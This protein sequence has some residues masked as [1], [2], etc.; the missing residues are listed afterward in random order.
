MNIWTIVATSKINC[1]GTHAGWQL[2]LELL[3]PKIFLTQASKRLFKSGEVCPVKSGL[4]TE[5]PLSL[6]YSFEAAPGPWFSEP[7]LCKAQQL[8]EV[9]T[10]N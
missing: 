7:T 1:I 2:Q 9:S 10:E 6:Q 8:S 5:M 4:G 3:I